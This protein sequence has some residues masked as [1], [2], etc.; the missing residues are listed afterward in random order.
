MNK[1]FLNPFWLFNKLPEP[2]CRAPRD[3]LRVVKTGDILFLATLLAGSESSQY[4]LEMIGPGSSRAL[5]PEPV[6][7][8]SPSDDNLDRSISRISAADVWSW[9]RDRYFPIQPTHDMD[10][11]RVKSRIRAV[12]I[13]RLIRDRFFS[14][15]QLLAEK[16]PAPFELVV[17]GVSMSNRSN[18]FLDF[19]RHLKWPFKK[20]EDPLLIDFHK[21]QFFKGNPLDGNLVSMD[22]LHCSNVSDGSVTPPSEPSGMVC[23]CPLDGPVQPLMLKLRTSRESWKNL[24]GREWN[25]WVCPHCLG[26]F[27]HQLWMMS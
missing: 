6:G 7:V 15:R 16:N 24:G 20:G 9:I 12:T 17:H 18:E 13:R 27:K 5:I 3:R 2:G 26:Q 14:L 22:A 8:E 23:Y 21:V 25:L 10:G 11:F 4:F 1:D 19:A